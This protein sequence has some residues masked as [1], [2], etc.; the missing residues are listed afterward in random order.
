MVWGQEDGR[1]RVK[2]S[3]RPLTP[4][5]RPL[6]SSDC[7]FKNDSARNKMFLGHMIL[8]SWRKGNSSGLGFVSRDEEGG[9]PSECVRNA[10]RAAVGR[11]PGGDLEAGTEGK[12]CFCWELTPSPPQSLLLRVSVVQKEN[13]YP[14]SRQVTAG[15]IL[16][17][18]HRGPGPG[19]TTSLFP[20]LW[21]PVEAGGRAGGN[22]TQLSPTEVFPVA[23]E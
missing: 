22:A 4:T 19:R 20:P 2:A 12:G 1:E 21:H 18:G 23:T 15:I 8:L 9:E 11:K 16:A 17:V 10:P 5:P 6:Q 3:P 14:Y 13:S 7:S